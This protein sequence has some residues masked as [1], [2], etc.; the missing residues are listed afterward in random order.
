MWGKV[1]IVDSTSFDLD[2]GSGAVV[3][4]IAAGYSGFGNGDYVSARGILD[5]S[6][7]PKTLTCDP[8]RIV[9]HN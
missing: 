3:R 4:V 2:D 6:G 1:T 9:K 8:A 5:V 7:S